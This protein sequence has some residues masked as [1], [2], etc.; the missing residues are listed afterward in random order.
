MDRY[1][2][3]CGHV[4][5]RWQGAIEDVLTFV[6]SELQDQG[7]RSSARRN[8]STLLSGVRMSAAGRQVSPKRIRLS[9]I[10]GPPPP[11]RVLFLS[12]AYRTVS[13]CDFCSTRYLGALYRGQ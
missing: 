4:R 10:D 9:T 8:S 12:D 13:A 6:L 7:R 11:Q 1:R 3:H 2:E 5:Q